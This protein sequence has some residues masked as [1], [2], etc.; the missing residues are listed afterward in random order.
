V[1]DNIFKSA[2]V[3]KYVTQLYKYHQKYFCQTFA[4]QKPDVNLKTC[5][6]QVCLSGMINFDRHLSEVYLL[7]KL[8]IFIGLASCVFCGL[9][10]E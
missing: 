10:E 7:K 1:I 3:I 9:L 5:F 4:K 2:N 8:I 6:Y